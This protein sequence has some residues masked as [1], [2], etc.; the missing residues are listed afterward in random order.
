MYVRPQ[1]QHG[2]F[3]MSL[4]VALLGNRVIVLLDA[5]R[6]CLL[7]KCSIMQQNYRWYKQDQ[8]LEALVSCMFLFVYLP[9]E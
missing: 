6:C 9:V 7:T 8:S 3:P 2:L 4:G 5:A 1:F